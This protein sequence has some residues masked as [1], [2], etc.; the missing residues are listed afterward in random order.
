MQKQ[1]SFCG[2]VD[3][4]RGSSI[5]VQPFLLFSLCAKCI[6]ILCFSTFQHWEVF[7]RC[8]CFCVCLSSMKMMNLLML[9]AVGFFIFDKSAAGKNGRLSSDNGMLCRLY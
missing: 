5:E 2:L 3:P 8:F 4:A 6:P 1:P 9:I 7:T